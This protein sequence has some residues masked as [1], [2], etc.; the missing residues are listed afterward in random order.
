MIFNRLI[1]SLLLKGGRLVKGVR[2]HDHRDAGN[3]VTTARA[4]NAQGADELVLIDIEASRLGRPPDLQTVVQ[5]AAECLM[6]LTV[7]GGI[8]S[9]ETA[10]ACMDNGA[11]KLLITTAAYERPE[12]IAELAH[13]Y[14]NQS[15]V[16][17]IDV[18]ETRD[19]WRLYDHRVS[20]P[21]NRRD[22]IDWA[23]RCV[24]LGAGEMRLMAV[25]REGMRGG[26]DVE[27]FRELIREIN[28]PVILEGGAGTLEHLDDAMKAGCTSVAVGTLLVF[29]DNNLMKVKRHLVNNG[30]RMRI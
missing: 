28:V 20:A 21:V 4:H 27:L 3:P 1:P 19:G 11:D 18:V 7:G 22:W 17:G 2:Y 30:H 16:V 15:V 5:V 25:S 29:S 8:G 13:V 26:M 9:V 6:P 12:I 23:K 24:T 10:K 14:G